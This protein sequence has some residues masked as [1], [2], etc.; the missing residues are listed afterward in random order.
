MSISRPPTGTLT[1]LVC[2]LIYR[3]REVDHTVSQAP[4]RPDSCQI[5]LSSRV[6]LGG[7]ESARDGKLELRAPWGWETHPSAAGGERLPCPASTI[8]T[9]GKKASA[10][11]ESLPLPLMGSGL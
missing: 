8:P 10:A 11:S 7:K 6:G 2:V 9:G 1:E 5:C 3:M 4:S